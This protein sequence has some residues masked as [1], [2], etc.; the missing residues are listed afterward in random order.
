MINTAEIDCRRLFSPIMAA[1]ASSNENFDWEDTF[2]NG[3][4]SV[5][6]LE[7]HGQRVKR[8]IF[9]N[10]TE[11][12]VCVDKRVTLDE[13]VQKF[14]FHPLFDTHSYSQGL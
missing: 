14:Q 6:V 5:T 9:K 3:K 10:R 11:R 4:T 7:C 1:F 8:E 12:S 2:R 13:I